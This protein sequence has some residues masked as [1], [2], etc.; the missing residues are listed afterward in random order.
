MLFSCVL[1]LSLVMRVVFKSTSSMYCL[2][3]C[4]SVLLKPCC[5]LCQV[6]EQFLKP[7]EEMEY[8]APD[9][10]EK[11]RY[12]LWRAAEIR[13]ALREGRQPA[14]P[15]DA[16]TGMPGGDAFAAGAAGG[17]M[18][19]GPAYDQSMPGEEQQGAAPG[20][21]SSCKQCWPVRCARL[22]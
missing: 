15:P 1:C 3:Y 4:S 11:T 2:V 13:K 17:D 22:A 16:G 8:A 12:A 18:F 5:V 20:G 14:P 6:L 9:L 10:L 21:C 19:S 7:G